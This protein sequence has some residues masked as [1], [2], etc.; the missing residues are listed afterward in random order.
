MLNRISAAH[1]SVEVLFQRLDWNPCGFAS[2]GVSGGTGT[3]DARLAG[4]ASPACLR[5]SIS[6]RT[7]LVVFA[8]VS[9]TWRICSIIRI[10]LPH[11]PER[12][13][14]RVVGPAL[15]NFHIEMALRLQGP[16]PADI[17]RVPPDGE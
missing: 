10:A 16:Y 9:V 7:R 2:F 12:R 4:C 3:G 5:R 15:R 11:P 8:A 1:R 13:R 14:V 17:T 6:L